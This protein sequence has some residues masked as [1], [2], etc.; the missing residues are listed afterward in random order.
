MNR[1]ANPLRRLAFAAGLAVAGVAQAANF[2]V[3]NT[4][5]AGPGSLRQ[6]VLDANA[7]P[8]ADSVEF[9]VTGP[10]ALT[11][12][13]LNVTDTLVLNGPG[14]DQLT[15]SAGGRSRLFN[16]S[17]GMVY[18]TGLTLADGF[19]APMQAGGG[20]LA[21]ADLILF[22][23]VVRNCQT[24]LTSGVNADG[25]GIFV[26]S[27]RTLTIEG[28]LFQGNR[29]ALGTGGAIRCASGAFLDA[30]NCTFSGNSATQGGALSTADP[31]A[32]DFCTF[33]DNSASSAGGGVWSPSAATRTS[34]SIFFRNSA[35]SGPDWLGAVNSGGFNIVGVGNGSSGWSQADR[36]SLDPMLG[37]LTSQGGN[38]DGYPLM[39][40]SPAMDTANPGSSVME[41]QRGMARP[42]RDQSDVGAFEMPFV[43]QPPIA[44][45]GVDQTVP[46]DG[47]SASVQLDGSGSSD[48]DG[49]DLEYAWLE[50]GNLLS[51]E[52]LPT[53]VLSNGT[54]VLTL[55]VTDEWGVSAQDQVVVTVEPP[56]SGDQRKPRIRGV[57]VRPHFLMPVDGNLKN[58][59]V[60]F[61]VKDN[62]DPNPLVWLTVTSSQA[63]GG[64]GK[65]DRSGDIVIVDK[66]N[67]KLR[68]ERFNRFRVYTITI[69]AKD[70]DGNLATRKV[71]VF[72]PCWRRHGR[73]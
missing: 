41:D 20:I 45:A 27:G 51:D 32:L 48:P 42:Q 12:G 29:V 19:A 53:V 26:G 67:V 57:S 28:C 38:G 69:N 5:D 6:A 36:L 23:C 55:V 13:Q 22:R 50:N 2:Q 72:V 25:G 34:N 4:A 14:A 52:M 60:N 58:V 49:D 31:A 71:R 37:P 64:L 56:A 46:S 15:I 66:N 30:R 68:A 18:M 59:R 16:L 62:N 61:Q 47:T 1:A 73:R 3:L 21:N 43:N 11:S 44:N 33:A 9:L 65:N 39:N 10:I 70:R 63:D 54:H 24:P 8:G 40:G 7:A 35:P 17:G